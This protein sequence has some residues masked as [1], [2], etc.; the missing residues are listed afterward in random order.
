MNTKWKPQG[1]IIATGEDGIFWE[2][3]ENGYLLFKPNGEQNTLSNHK[4]S[5]SWKLKYSDEIIAIGF[6]NKVYAPK[7]SSSLFRLP[8][9]EYIEADK[10]D[11]SKVEDMSSM[12]EEAR[13]LTNLNI[14]N[15][16]TSN[17]VTMEAMF[18]R[19][20]NLTKI[21]IGKWNMNNVKN[22]DFM[23]FQS[24]S[25]QQLNLSNIKLDYEIALTWMLKDNTSLKLLDFSQ[26]KQTN[27]EIRNILAQLMW[28]DDIEVP[29]ECIVLLPN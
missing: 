17:V 23:F 22:M 24:K 13:C 29:N 9:L 2:L 15:W 6:S 5:P 11:T 21:D 1:K 8:Y 28:L 19:T 7:N 27:G 14:S 12:F 10:I 4:S 26:S 20:T 18:C 3:N 16:D 25:I